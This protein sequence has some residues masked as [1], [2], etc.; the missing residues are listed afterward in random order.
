[1]D[2]STLRE[3]RIFLSHKIWLEPHICCP[4]TPLP[5]MSSK[6]KANTYCLDAEFDNN[7]WFSMIF[8]WPLRMHSGLYITRSLIHMDLSL[9]QDECDIASFCGRSLYVLPGLGLTSSLV[10]IK[11]FRKGRPPP[12]PPPPNTH[13]H[14]HWSSNLYLKLA[15]RSKV[16]ETL[17]FPK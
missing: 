13:T 17:E 5:T 12:P 8:E 3:F 1:M 16:T 10:I 2:S 9:D 7:R 6:P 4:L 15:Q 11:I 14:T